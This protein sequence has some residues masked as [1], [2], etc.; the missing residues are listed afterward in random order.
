MTEY[1]CYT[2]ASTLKHLE[3]PRSGIA[4]V[5]VN[6]DYNM[7]EKSLAQQIDVDDNIFAELK[8]INLGIGISASVLCEDDLLRICTDCQPAMDMINSENEN[9]NPRINRVLKKIDNAVDRLPCDIQFQW[10]KSHSE[11]PVNDFADMLAYRHAQGHP[12]DD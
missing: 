5:V 3:F 1:N 2:D 12:Y 8:A 4:A 6:L 11:H 9:R 7:M 10:V